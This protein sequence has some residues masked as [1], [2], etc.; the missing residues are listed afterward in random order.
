VS[1]SPL[2]VGVLPSMGSAMSENWWEAGDDIRTRQNAPHRVR[3]LYS[4]LT[5]ANEVS[6]E[7]ESVVCG[8]PE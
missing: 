5:F 8:R 3:L 6:S 4:N 2:E 1:L 7:L